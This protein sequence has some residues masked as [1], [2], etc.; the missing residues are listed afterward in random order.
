MKKKIQEWFN[1]PVDFFGRNVHTEWNFK[2][3]CGTFFAWSP[4]IILFGSIQ[5]HTKKNQ[6]ISYPSLLGV[7]VQC[8]TM[9]RAVPAA[10]VQNFAD[11][12]AEQQ[13]LKEVSGLR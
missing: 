9:V 1:Y 2:I 6:I 7:Q 11:A 12:F 13:R 5:I 10:L 3:E 8:G 4:S